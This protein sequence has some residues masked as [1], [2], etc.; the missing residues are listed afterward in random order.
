MKLDYSA[1]YLANNLIEL[2]HF[3]EAIALQLLS[4][5]AKYTKNLVFTT[6]LKYKVN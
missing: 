3:F 5:Y 6:L 1:A 2:G 4:Y